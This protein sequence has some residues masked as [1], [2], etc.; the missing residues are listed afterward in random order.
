MLQVT[1]QALR[2][3]LNIKAAP[4]FGIGGNI[5]P[6]I[7]V[8]ALLEIELGKGGILRLDASDAASFT[9]VAN[10]RGLD[11]GPR[12]AEFMHIALAARLG[13][14]VNI[15]LRIVFIDAV[16]VCLGANGAVELGFMDDLAGAGGF[17]PAPAVRKRQSYQTNFKPP[18]DSQTQCESG[19]SAASRINS[20][21]MPNIQI[22]ASTP[23]RFQ[24]KNPI[25]L[26][27]GNP[28]T[29]FGVRH[30][31]L[32]VGLSAFF[33]WREAALADFPG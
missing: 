14:G 29:R 12:A 27:P 30:L 28:G 26:I 20:I 16:T 7:D 33:E 23:T 5:I 6:I 3:A 11:A 13:V 17:I 4:P 22:L 15:P 25:I 8:G 21:T 10:M 18:D 31:T 2:N 19:G 1:L 9:G 24:F 32:N